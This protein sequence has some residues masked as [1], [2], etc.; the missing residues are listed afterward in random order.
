MNKN[1]PPT[2]NSA[3]GSEILTPDAA[4]VSSASIGGISIFS[5]PT[6]DSPLSNFSE[7][8]RISARSRRISAPRESIAYILDRSRSSIPLCCATCQTPTNAPANARTAAA[9]LLVIKSTKYSN[10]SEHPSERYP[11]TTCVTITTLVPMPEVLG[12]RG[13]VGGTISFALCGSGGSQ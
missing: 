9:R 5:E 13:T 7:S 11:I 6:S 12:G 2:T 3:L 4:E 1:T 10:T 8:R